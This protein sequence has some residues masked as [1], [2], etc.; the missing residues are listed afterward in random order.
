M[1]FF[2]KTPF[3]KAIA[4][5]LF[6]ALATIAFFWQVLLLPNT[7]MPAGGGDL[8]PFLYPNYHFAA[9]S[10]KA[11]IIPLWNPHLYAG[12]PFAADAQ[13]G[14][15]YPPNLLSFLSLPEIRVRT[16]I[17]LAI[18]HFWWAGVGMYL[19]L[20]FSPLAK[21][22]QIQPIAAFSGA[23]AF[24]FSDLFIVH[25]GNLNMIAVAAWLPFVMLAYQKALVEQKLAYTLL[26][27]LLLG[28][29]SLAGH[30]QIT[31]F[32]LLALGLF[33]LWHSF[34]NWQEKSSWPNIGQNFLF[35][36]L[37]LMVTLGIS[38]LWFV[39]TLEMSRYTLRADLNYA[40][41]TAYALNPAQLVGL[42]IPGYFG[43][44]PALHW[45][46][47]DRVETGYIGILTLL[48]ACIGLFLNKQKNA[49]F[50][51]LLALTSFLLALGDKSILHGWLS[52]SPGFGQFRAPARYILLLDF[53]LATL[54]CL[55]LQILIQAA[56]ALKLRLKRLLLL[57]GLSLGSLTVISLPL[58]YY[59]LMVTQDRHAD[60]FRRA[61]LAAE[62]LSLFALLLL[63]SFIVLYLAYQQRLKGF[64]LGLV[65]CVLIIFDLFSLGANI[66][67]GYTNPAKSYEHP[68]ALNYLQDNLGLSR[69]EVTTDIW[70]LWQ[71]NFA[72]RYG[73]YDAWGLYNPLTLS[74]PTR[75]WQSNKPRHSPLY[76]LLGIKYIIASKAGAPADGD[77][78]PVFD[79]DPDVNI[80]LN[81]SALPRLLFVPEAVFVPNQEAAW[82]AIHQ[83]DFDPQTQ[84]ILEGQ[85]PP[86]SL[87]SSAEKKAPII[88]LLEYGL[89]T[90]QI[91]VNSQQA[92][93]LFLSDS[94]YPGWKAFVN[95]QEERIFRANYTF[96]AI[97]VGAGENHI[98][99]IFAPLS[100]KLGLGLSLCT[101]LSLII[102]FGLAWRSTRLI[103]RTK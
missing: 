72:L 101:G 28:I 45:G 98:R 81:R 18:F 103:N 68:E 62:G 2:P 21:A 99:M 91:S 56:P 54:A 15:F 9:Q 34:S 27:G 94:Y 65:A 61:T 51:G 38:A 11:G 25:F 8:V 92:G 37:T 16:L 33:T 87:P 44:D 82:E 35:L 24:E 102:Y 59:A 69:I 26:G 93:Y 12:I 50:M 64:K 13:S 31:L 4:A 20:Q 6:L 67:I 80:Y 63:S 70:H 32:I 55:G 48:L 47:W 5:S 39:P 97:A 17:A 23:I 88:A 29:A 7:W 74:G 52:L 83:A 71:P 76:N 49:Q 85:T 53:A 22:Y 41:S 60:I 84:V 79:Q 86:D 40:E 1:R 36:S 75:Y 57:M 3:Q 100:W 78:V 30:I 42:F 90:I 43:R 73:L 10:L 19:F 95:G 89:H 66:D 96:R 46:P 14:L 58:A 77:I